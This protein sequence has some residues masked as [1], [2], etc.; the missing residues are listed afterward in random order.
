MSDHLLHNTV[1]LLKG[2]SVPKCPLVV[3][4]TCQVSFVAIFLE[5]ISGLTPLFRSADMRFIT[6][7]FYGKLAGKM[8]LEPAHDIMRWNITQA[9]FT[10]ILPNKTHAC[11]TLL[12][13][14]PSILDQMF[15]S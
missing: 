4:L 9:R 3:R 8:L 12:G 10:K 2:L 7:S 1:D 15:L 14:K 11:I 5:A 6:Q 13:Y